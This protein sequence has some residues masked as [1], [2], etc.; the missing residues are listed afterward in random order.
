MPTSSAAN[1]C[2]LSPSLAG[3]IATAAGVAVAF[4]ALLAARWYYK[5][6]LIGKVH[7][8]LLELN[9]LAVQHPKVAKAF[10]D[11][12]HRDTPY[13]VPIGIPRDEGYYA[14]RGYVL[15]RLNIYEEVFFATQG[16]FASTTDDGRAWQRYIKQGFRHPRVRELFDEE[17]DQFGHAFIRF[18]HF[19]ELPGGEKYVEH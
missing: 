4:V 12:S 6:T 8:R 10:F 19:N 18:I 7:D 16:I 15:F 1:A 14:L 2:L 9:K 5:R 17:L 13:F 11:Q 3:P